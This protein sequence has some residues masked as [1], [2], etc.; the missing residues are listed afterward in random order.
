MG[1]VPVTRGTILSLNKDPDEGHCTP[2]TSA[3]A[4]L[5]LPCSSLPTWLGEPPSCPCL[6]SMSVVHLPWP[7]TL[8]PAPGSWVQKARMN[9]RGIGPVL[10]GHSQQ[11]AVGDTERR[12]GRKRQLGVC[13]CVCVYDHHRAETRTADSGLIFK[14]SLHHQTYWYY[15]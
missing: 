7:P 12:N 5:P 2:T 15:A 6:S 8:P 10:A 9:K 11:G 14:I 1:W 3:E 13:V 4:L